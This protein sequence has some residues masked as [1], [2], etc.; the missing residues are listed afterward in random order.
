M[1][2]LMIIGLVIM[3]SPVVLLFALSLEPL[4]VG[5]AAMISVLAIISIVISATAVPRGSP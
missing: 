3:F 2:A 5:A 1:N 4:A